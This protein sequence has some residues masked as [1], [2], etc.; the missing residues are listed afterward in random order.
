MIDRKIVIATVIAIALIVV[1]YLTLS[2]SAQTPVV[3]DGDNVQVYYTG[4]FTNGTVFNSNVG[5]QPFNFTVGSGQVIQGFDSAVIGMKL[6][7]S[8]TV[9]IP[10]N[11][12]YGPVDPGLII[13]VPVK[14]F[15]NETASVGMAVVRTSNG[16]QTR[17]VITA[18]NATNATVN[19]NSP[20][21]G[22]TL[23][24]EIRVVGIEK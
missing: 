6:N 15:G 2:S 16:Q 3:A 22:Q 11:Q 8:K 18:L 5:S 4:S 19:F 13:S 21:A 1:V 17:G 7:Q 23:V 14:D 10:A 24:F 12:A 9:T 20:L